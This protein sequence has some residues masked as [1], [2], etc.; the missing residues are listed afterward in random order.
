M[1]FAPSSSRRSASSGA[2]RAVLAR[3]PLPEGR[4]TGGRSGP[5][6]PPLVMIVTVTPLC[7]RPACA[8]WCGSA[9]GDRRRPAAC[10]VSARLARRPTRALAAYDGGTRRLPMPGTREHL[11]R[12]M[13]AYERFALSYDLGKE[14]RS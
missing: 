2:G 12:T 5:R 14:D 13:A 6:P 3:H 4:G 10:R 11:L 1:I 8:V 7:A 9:V